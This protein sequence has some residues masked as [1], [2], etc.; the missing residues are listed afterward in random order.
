MLNLTIIQQNLLIC[1]I[2]FYKCGERVDKQQ[3]MR[4]NALP[5]GSDDAQVKRWTMN[6]GQAANRR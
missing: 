5:D 3:R 2:H 4:D 6:K 1:F